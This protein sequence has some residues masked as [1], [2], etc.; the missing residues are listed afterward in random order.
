MVGNYV[1]CQLVAFGG[2][3]NEYKIKYYII[4]DWCFSG[5]FGRATPDTQQLVSPLML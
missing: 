2:S 3:Y 4:P 5:S 1:A